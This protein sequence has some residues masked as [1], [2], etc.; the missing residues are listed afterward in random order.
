MNI[1]LLCT[2]QD[3]DY[4]DRFQ[5]LP[6]FNGHV[7]KKSSAPVTNV[8]SLD[9]A[10]DRLGIDAIV[11]TQ[12]ATLEILLRDTTDWV[13]P[14]SS[15]KK[16]TL[17]DYAGSMFHLRSGREVVVLNPL[18]RL[19]TV[20]EEKFVVDRYISKLTKKHKWLPQTKFQWS[21]VTIDNADR[22]LAKVRAAD[23]V[24]IDIENPY[25]QY[26][27]RPITCVSYT[28]Y[29]AKTHTTESYVVEFGELWAW[30]FIRD[31][32][33][34][35][36]R[37]VFQGGLHDNAYFLRW[38]CPVRSWLFDTYHLFHSW[39]AE[40]PRRLDF[41]TSF[42]LRDVR[43]WKDEGKTG[44]YEDLARY[45]AKDG[46]ATINSL[47]AILQEAPAW[48]INNYTDHEFPMVFPSLHASME[49]LD[50]DIE[51]FMEIK[52][53]KGVE[54]NRLLSR[55]Q[56]IF[57]D[58]NYNP[59]SWQ[60][61]ERVFK[62]LGAGHIEGTGKIS[63]LKA[64]ALHPLN[65]MVLADVENYKKEA[66]QV[67]T[68]FDETKFWHNRI[69]YAIDPGGTDTLR[70]ASRESHF[71]CG[72][73]VQNTPRDDSSFKECV[74]APPGWYI[75]EVDK[76]QSEARCV[77]Y[78]SG[79]LAL[80][81]LVESDKDYH[82]WNASKFFGV[83]YAAIYEQATGKTLDK[84]LRDLSKRTNHGANYNMGASV[85]LDT[86]GPK[87]VAQ[88]KVTLKLPK[89]WTLK[90][91]C[92]YLLDRYAATYPDVK[93]RWYASIIEQVET[94]GILVSPLGWVR[95]CFG[96]PKDN[97]QHLNSLVAHPPQN[98]S[99][100]II[101]KEWYKIW[102]ATVYGDL[103]GRVRI[104]AQIHDSLLFIYRKVEDALAVQGM[105]DFRVQ[106]VGSDNVTRTLFIP[107]D[108]SIGDVPTRRWSEIK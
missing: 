77:A 19:R 83:D 20:P 44:R 65:D 5:R 39:L 100:S 76:K 22:V 96:K 7:L 71:D 80:I 62:L 79:D 38:G 67:G 84:A 64:R 69:Y 56:Y 24:G 41:I 40:L 74:L 94:H 73:Q 49:G 54:V 60:Q 13:R 43:Y 81:N 27:W 86:M 29:F 14:E 51:R 23:L 57:G 98:L 55:L 66:K 59:G 45:C 72:W 9:A 30:E 15:K 63:T 1:V 12:Q 37:K 10:C 17:D 95:K 48:A 53:R 46:W 88:A 16:I 52:K 8:A 32:N 78:L 90:A 108:L 28:C 50:A 85:M 2:P 36:S 26:D 103:R 101:N 93:G 58:P 92:Q 68:Y 107:S 75:A 99:V 104:K 6:A 97:K 61:N 106:V 47:L 87:K 70:A 105:M 11:C 18:E 3:E 34:A 35:P 31:A 4:L 82:A 91:V 25:P 21:H 33:D 42:V 102:R 89:R